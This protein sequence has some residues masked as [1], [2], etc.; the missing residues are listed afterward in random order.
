[1]TKARAKAPVRLP[2]GLC[3]SQRLRKKSD[4]LAVRL[5]GGTVRDGL[6]LIGF[7]ENDRAF[8]RLGL[9]VG[10][11]LGHAVCRNRIK[12]IIREA[13]RRERP[14][15]PKGLDLVVVPLDAKRAGELLPVRASLRKLQTRVQIR[16]EAAAKKIRAQER[17]SP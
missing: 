6:L 13:F 4:F 2:Q 16:L 1:M 17:G 11:R 8:T 12:R 15:F 9:A 7:L 10:R 3:R 5:Q 14:G